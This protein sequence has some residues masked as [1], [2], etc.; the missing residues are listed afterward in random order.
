MVRSCELGGALGI[1]PR[2]RARE[3]QKTL[4]AFGYETGAPHPLC[5]DTAAFMKA[6]EGDKKRK[7]GK[8]QFIVPAQEGAERAEIDGTPGGSGDLSGK[9]LILKI[10][11]GE[12]P[13]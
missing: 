5:K 12:Y 11:N 8:L 13:L 10:I 9:A 7:N 4:E 2:E 6:L 1:T 3:I